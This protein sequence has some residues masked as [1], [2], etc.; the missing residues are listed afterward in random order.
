MGA[1]VQVRETDDAGYPHIITDLVATSRNRTDWEELPALQERLAQPYVAA[2]Y[3][4]GPNLECSRKKPIDWI[5]PLPN[6]VA[7][8]DWL[9]EGLTQPHFQGDA[10]NNMVTGPQGH[11]ATKPV[12]DN[13]SLSF[14][15]P[16]KTCR[17][18]ALRRRC[19][20]GNAGRTVGMSA[21]YELTEAARARQ[22]T[23]ACKPEYPQPRS[24]GEG[25]RSAVVRGHGMRDSRYSGQNK[26]NLQ[27]IFTG[28]AANL[29]GR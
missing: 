10:K 14:R 20:T 29:I 12:P 5:G 6:F 9:P 24:G 16:L 15:F 7:P 17:P 22:K 27:A 13:N 25:S 19:C 21:Y 1:K 8:Q 23:E 2:G 4:S 18:C 28:C 3:R 11:M 26:R